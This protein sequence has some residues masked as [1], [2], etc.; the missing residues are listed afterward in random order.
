MF[1]YNGVKVGFD[2][3]CTWALAFIVVQFCY[4]CIPLQLAPVDAAAWSPQPA[5]TCHGGV[6]PSV[7]HLAPT[8]AFVVV[9]HCMLIDAAWCPVILTFSSLHW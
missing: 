2:A 5:P 3:T 4:S 8:L 1:T 6:S 9:P 7:M